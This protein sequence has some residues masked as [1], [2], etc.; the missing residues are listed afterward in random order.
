MH[1]PSTEHMIALK[2]IL[3]YVQGT[4][5][6]GLHLPPSPIPKLISYTN[7]D[8][9][10]CP[11]TRRSTSGSVF[12]SVTILSLGLPKG[13]LLS[14]VLVLKLNIEVLQMLSLNPVG[15]ATFF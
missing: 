11:D 8:W 2:R 14:L 4:I 5:H 3:C 10:G 7:A 9:G 1:A 15:S 6:L 13:S 12:F